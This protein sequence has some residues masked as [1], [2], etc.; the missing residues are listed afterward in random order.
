MT[1][2]N[3]NFNRRRFPRIVLPKDHNDLR[4]IIG[5]DA[6]IRTGERVPVLDLSYGGAALLLK[7]PVL[8]EKVGSSL[9][10]QLIFN[11]ST[12]V[13]ITAEVVR[14]SAAATGVRFFNMPAEARLEFDRFLNDQMLG[15]NT[16]QVR[17]ELL[18]NSNRGDGLTCWYHGPKDTNIFIWQKHAQIERA[19]IEL[20]Y[21][22]LEYIQGELAFGQ[23]PM[24]SEFFVDGYSAY[25]EK[26]TLANNVKYSQ[27]DLIKR[28]ISVL[29]Q[30]PKKSSEVSWLVDILLGKLK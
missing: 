17:P 13:P 1:I 21:Q 16:H 23:A 19:V 3:S 12:H 5:I 30:I 25:L 29:S 2:D 6:K 15:L 24:D 10:L 26:A 11:G 9:D 4:Q 8:K 18:T 28:A 14:N 20:D 22:V 27:I 7:D